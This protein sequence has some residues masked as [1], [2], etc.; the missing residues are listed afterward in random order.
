MIDAIQETVVLLKTMQKVFHSMCY[1]QIFA[2]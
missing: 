2:A 1:K